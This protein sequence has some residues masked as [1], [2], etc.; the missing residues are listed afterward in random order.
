MT[1]EEDKIVVEAL[2]RFRKCE[3]SSAEIR[4]AMLDDLKFLSGDQWDE[5]IKRERT[6]PGMER[7]C[8][9]VDRLNPVINQIVN[10]GRQNRQQMKVRPAGGEDEPTAKIIDGMVRYIQNQ[11]DS[12]S[13]FDTAL[14]YAV[15]CSMGYFQIRNDW[16]DE[17]SFDQKIVI[18]RIENPLTVYFPVHLCKASDYSDAPY[19]FITDDVP[20]EDFKAEY[21]DVDVSSWEATGIGDTGNTW[22]TE[23]TVRVAEYF[24]KEEKTKT[25]YL[26]SNGDVTDNKG[27]LPEGVTVVKSRESIETKVMWYKLCSGAI[28]DKKEIPC[29]WIPVIPVTGVEMNIGGKK[30]Y[31][32]AIRFAK[33]S[34]K[35]MNYLKSCQA[36]RIALAP[37]SPWIAAEGQIED[38]NDIWAVANKRNIGVLPYKPQSISGVLVGAP[39]R[40]QA[41]DVSVGIVETIKETVDD[42]KAA[43]GIYDASLG[44][45]SNETSG[46]AIIA[47]QKEGDT[48]N[49]H[50]V[51]NLSRSMRHCTRIIVDMV[52]KIYVTAR[53]VRTLGN[54]FTEAVAMVNAQYNNGEN[55]NPN[56][57]LYDITAG[58]YDVVTD[59]GPSYQ[60]QRQETSELLVSLCQ[61]NPQLAANTADLQAKLA[62]APQDIIDRFRKMLPPGLVEQNKKDI[63]AQ[64][65]QVM[66]EQYKSMIQTLNQLVEKMGSE[67]ERLEFEAKN[68]TAQIEADILKTQMNNETQI[69]KTLLTNSHAVGMDASK[70]AYENNTATA[71]LINTLS[72][73]LEQIETMLQKTGTAPARNAAEETRGTQ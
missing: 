53:I 17:N 40:V 38:Y 61:G 59:T 68:K 72:A 45:R 2:D 16:E 48:A 42:I 69:E 58:K 5:G 50:F 12:Q 20:T 8:L 71:E 54:D 19:C 27:N 25:I 64:Q 73:R 47:R 31:F 14:E 46:K 26:L 52:P 32:S 7:P 67:I 30:K 13:A 49:Y 22:T 44:A 11:S 18:D 24:V 56:G 70:R 23:D 41:P 10:D 33:D 55:I 35:M 60:T 36:E 39:Q 66:E 65:V 37:L 28:L 51:D 62:G 9:V 15:R 29:K 1:P 63:P 34:Q 57:E 6:L 3:E 4:S 21:P 43:T